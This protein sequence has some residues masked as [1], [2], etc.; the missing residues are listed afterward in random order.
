MRTKAAV[1]LMMILFPL[2]IVFGQEQETDPFFWLEDVNGEKPLAWVTT[3]NERTLG[4]L[5]SDPRYAQ[6][7]AE[8]ISIYTSDQRIPNIYGVEGKWIYNLWKDEDSPRGIFRRTTRSSYRSSSPEWEIILDV[9]RLAKDED[10]NWVW[11]GLN[12]LPPEESFCLLSLSDGGKDAKIV[13]EFRMDTRS[14]VSP[15]NGGFY[16]PE[17]KSRVSWFDE[18]TIFVATDFGEG[19][20]TESGYPRIVKKWQRGTPLSETKTVLEGEVSDVSIWSWI[21]ID[22]KR[23]QTVVLGRSVTFYDYEQSLLLPDGTLRPIPL[24]SQYRPNGI[25]NGQIILTLQQD[26]EYQGRTWQMGDLVSF[27]LES[28]NV[29]LIYHPTKSQSVR[30]VRTTRNTVLVPL[31]DNVVGKVKRFKRNRR[32]DWVGEDVTL[33]GI[34][35]VSVAYSDYRSD[36]FFLYFENPTEPDALYHVSKRNKLEVWKQLPAM[37]DSSDVVVEQRWASSKDG[38]RIPY[39]RPVA[40]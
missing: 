33:P 22:P 18:N 17:A 34:G 9:D 13:R 35:S 14:F 19:S 37:Y 39:F 10:K 29:R 8:A 3:Q 25:L 23:K 27:D 12:C 5:K 36:E 6:I 32:G 40:K 20:L 31:L 2:T 16:L 28:Q 26:W 15:D 11:G 7:E 21:D 38:T 24:P 1:F 4:E 30:R